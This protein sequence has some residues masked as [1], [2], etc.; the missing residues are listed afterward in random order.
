MKL[1]QMI[2]QG[3]VSIIL[4]YKKADTA[5]SSIQNTTGCLFFML[6]TNA[7]GG[8]IANIATFSS[9]RSIFI[10]ERMSNSY[11]TLAYYTGRSMSCIP[12]EIFLPLLFMVIAYFPSN[13]DNS[14][15]VFFMSVLAIELCYFMAASYGLMISTIIKDFNVAIA[16]VPVLIIPQML[17]AGYFVTLNQVPHFFYWLE[18]ISAFKYGFASLM[19]NQY[20][21]PVDCGDGQYCDLVATRFKFPDTFIVSMFLMLTVGLIFRI[22][23]FFGMVIISS[24]KRVKLPAEGEQKE[25]SFGDKIKAC[26]GLL[27]PPSRPP[28]T[29]PRPVIIEAAPVTSYALQPPL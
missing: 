6:M 11:S 13:L 16:L 14:T 1:L 26:C 20:R 17:V 10:R 19:Y 29:Q 23:A 4:F 7:F 18:Y 9:E 8:I 2:V 27:K 24:P 3:V 5:F 28:A 22:I 12:I 25:L 21:H 15:G